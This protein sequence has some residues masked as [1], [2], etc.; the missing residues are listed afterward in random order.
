MPGWGVFNENNGEW[1]D[2]DKE[3]HINYLELKVG[4][5][6]LTK[7]CGDIGNG[8]VRLYMDNSVDS[9]LL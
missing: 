9:N 5:I 2:E 1:L 3:K 8:H 4:F 7:F 6:A